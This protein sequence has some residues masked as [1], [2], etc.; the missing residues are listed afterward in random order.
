LSWAFFIQPEKIMSKQDV[1][2]IDA[3]TASIMESMGP[4]KG[5]AILSS[6]ICQ[7]YAETDQSNAMILTQPGEGVIVITTSLNATDQIPHI[8]EKTLE[9]LPEILEK[10]HKGDEPEGVHEVDGDSG[11]LKKTPPDTTI[12]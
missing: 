5:I 7:L 6:V 2:T 1:E 10:V 3:L 4:E 9:Q 8:I 11:E 12:H